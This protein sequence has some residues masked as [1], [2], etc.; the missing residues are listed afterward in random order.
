MWKASLAC[1]RFWVPSPEHVHMR[2]CIH[3][4]TCIHMHVNILTHEIMQS[5]S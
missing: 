2:V 4:H 1:V 3:M 5:F